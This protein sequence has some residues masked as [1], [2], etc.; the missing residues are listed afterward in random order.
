M[1]LLK[2]ARQADGSIMGDIVPLAQLVEPGSAADVSKIVSHPISM[3]QVL[4]IL[5]YIFI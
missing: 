4:P 5:V 3:R 2:H 1:H